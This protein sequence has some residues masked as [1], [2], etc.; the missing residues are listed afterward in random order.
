MTGARFPF[1]IILAVEVFTFRI[2]IGGVEIPFSI[3][4]AGVGLLGKAKAGIHLNR[5]MNGWSRIPF[6]S[7]L[8]CIQC[9]AE[10]LLYG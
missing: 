5:I 6:R 2:V 7:I 4:M 3:K 10:L 8:V 1:R 9:N